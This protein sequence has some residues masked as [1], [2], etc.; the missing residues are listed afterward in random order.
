MSAAAAVGRP[1]V[2]RTWEHRDMKM[3][4]A[5]TGPHQGGRVTAPERVEAGI[6]RHRMAEAAQSKGLQ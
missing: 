2:R 6:G 3:A 1:I 5:R 4:G